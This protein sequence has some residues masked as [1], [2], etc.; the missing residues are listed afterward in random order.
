[1]DEASRGTLTAGVDEVGRGPLAGPVMAAAVILR[2]PVEGLTD[3]K[4]LSARERARLCGLI[5][6]HGIVAVGA[7]SVREIEQLNILGATMLAMRRAVGR[8][9]VRPA[10]VLVDGDREPGLGLATR[11]V[12]GGDATVP[13]ISAASIVAKVARD[14]L[15]QRLAARCPGYGWERNA[16]YGTPEHRLALARLGLSR[17]HRLGFAPCARLGLPP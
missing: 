13:E 15:M 1:M 10:R 6:E 5:R 17:H 3:S 8:L 7:A 14:L 11:C 9:P 4:Q 12:V 16:G 2:R